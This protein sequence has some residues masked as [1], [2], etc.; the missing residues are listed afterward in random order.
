[1]DDKTK[2]SRRFSPAKLFKLKNRGLLLD[3]VVFFLNLF[4]MRELS[5]RFFGLVK[6]SAAGESSATLI[7]FLFFLS[8]LFLAPAGA[9]LKRWRFHQRRKLEGKKDV[10]PDVMGGCLFNPIFYFCL[11]VVVFSVTNA[12]VLEFFSKGSEPD[13][14]LFVSLILG[15]FLMI[16]VTTFF[17]YRYF[18]PPKHEPRWSFLKT[19]NA[20]TLG[21]ICIFLNMIFFQILWNGLMSAPTEGVGSI[22]EFAARLFFLLFAALLVYFPPRIFYLY[23]DIG[24]RRTWITILLANAPLIYRVMIGS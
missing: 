15:G 1:M 10:E 23:E 16:I 24:K 21:D 5:A 6:S 7:I 12:F 8:L 19:Q 20:E 4:L 2:S 14:T 18:S 9:I 22:S 11:S 17:V 13:G 3:I